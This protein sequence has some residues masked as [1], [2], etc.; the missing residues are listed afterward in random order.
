MYNVCTVIVPAFHAGSIIPFYETISMLPYIL[1]S[2]AVLNQ[3]LRHAGEA[4]IEIG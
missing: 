1:F 3:A 2:L 4:T